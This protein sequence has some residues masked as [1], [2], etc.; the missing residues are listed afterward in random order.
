VPWLTAIL[1]APDPALQ[2]PAVRA[3]GRIGGEGA[4][5]PVRRHYN[6]PAPEPGTAPSSPPPP[7]ALA[8]EM[9]A[10][11]QQGAVRQKGTGRQVYD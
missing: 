8:Q 3:L 6:A 2:M 5:A 11:L 4:L 1:D 9:R 7:P 10:A